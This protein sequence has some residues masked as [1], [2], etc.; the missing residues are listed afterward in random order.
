MVIS[1]SYKAIKLE[2]YNNIKNNLEI[3]VL[4]LI[5]FNLDRIFKIAS[6]K[7]LCIKAMRSWKGSFREKSILDIYIK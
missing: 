6:V 1:S 4:Q 5:T 2:I 3:Y 7:I